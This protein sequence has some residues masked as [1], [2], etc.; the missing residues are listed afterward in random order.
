MMMSK[1]TDEVKEESAPP[2]FAAPPPTS[3]K[4]GSVEDLERK[5]KM[6]SSTDGETKPPAITA[7]AVAAA[8]PV[9]ST[10]ASAAAVKGGKNALLARIMAAKEKSQQSKTVAAP[11][12]APAPPVQVMSSNPTVDLL[13]DFDA[14]STA[15]VP[16][17]SY[18]TNFLAG[19]PPPA[20]PVAEA[21]A[22][23]PAFDAVENTVMQQVNDSNPPPPSIDDV[24]MPPPPP[25]QD[26]VAPP[27]A[28][29]ASAPSFEDLLGGGGNNT[30][31]QQQEF[32]PPPVPP[33]AQLDID[34]SILNALEPAEREAF[35][36]EQRKIME[37]I[38]KEKVGNEASGAAA[39][40]AAFD[41]RS[42]AAVANV[43]ASYDTSSSS[44]SRP[45]AS[46]SSRSST[47]PSASASSSRGT[48]NLG[49][50]AEVP[51]HGQEK[52]QQAIKDG[53]A[54]IVQCLSC[55]NW[56]QV[57]GEAEVMMCPLC[58]T[59]TRVERAGAATTADMEAAAQMAADA[60]LAEKLQKEEYARASG[61]NRSRSRQAA[62]PSSSSQR[63]AQSSSSPGQEQGWMDW[64]MGVP[65]PAPATSAAIASG[66]HSAE[67]RPQAGLVSAQ[68]GEERLGGGGP[69]PSFGGGG[70]G[71]RV[72][73][74]KSMFS[75]VA[76][77]V[78]T[79]ATQMS[80]Y[81]LPQDDEGN[82][83][84]VDGSSLLAMPNEDVSR[85]RE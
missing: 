55:N 15:N 80:A 38:E 81:S 67:I 64:I 26:V 32:H 37:Q 70:G 28:P 59:I 65:A 6:L 30:Q 18:D 58:N 50:G 5:L 52:T 1:P 13:G 27:A 66:A 69:S 25:A 24:F 84:G 29:A 49:E 54:L 2:A 36:E 39:R 16:P 34:E 46:S 63:Q 77:A 41:Q 53:T 73:E 17:P 44:R 12:P 60:E 4:V 45:A 47:A 72:A 56:M 74:Q 61:G 3:L 82:Y 43:A 11:A 75:C 9:P 48:V 42:T 20:A 35:L 85:Q 57:T 8:P 76:D 19:V 31:Q 21:A 10:A 40:A 78:G 7:P 79:A 14:P 71:A 68:T 23:P 83:H 62:S 22:A 51:L 33:P